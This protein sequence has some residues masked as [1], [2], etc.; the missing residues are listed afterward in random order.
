MKY[1]ITYKGLDTTTNQEKIIE[2]IREFYKDKYE[3]K[4]RYYP[5]PGAV[6]RFDWKEYLPGFSV[7]ATDYTLVIR[8]DDY[9]I[10]LSINGGDYEPFS[11]KELDFFDKLGFELLSAFEDRTGQDIS[12]WVDM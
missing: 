12:D 10:Y 9:L 5:E 2:K 4:E 3:L 11:P 7:G 6:T 8:W 1:K